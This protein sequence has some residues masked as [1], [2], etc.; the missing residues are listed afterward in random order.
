[1][2][3]FSPRSF[4]KPFEYERAFDY[5][6][7]QQSAHWLHLEI[8]MSADISDWHQNMNENEKNVVGN[9]LKS[10]TQTE[11]FIQEYWSNQ[12]M[13]W[14]KKPE[15]QMMASTF[16]SFE[17]IHSAGYDYLN[18]S[19]G[20]DDYQAFMLDS[21]AKAKID[22]LINTRGKSRAEIAKALAIFSAFNEGVNLFSSFAVLMSFPQRNLLK[23][24]GQ[25]V[26]WSIRD[27]AMHSEA[28]CWLFR[29]LIEEQPELFTEE[30]KKDIYDA[31][32]LTIELE[33][34]F[35]DKAFE[36]GPLPNLHPDDLKNYIRY[37][38]NSKLQEL[39]LKQNW[40]NLN[41]ESLD[42]LQWFDV[43]SSGVELADF[44]ATR[45][46]QY[47]KNVASFGEVW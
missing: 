41:K 23:G 33:D 1:M 36:L 2:S 12:V 28:G 11:T 20:L 7:K 14:F 39:G 35:I 30:L 29:T 37:R 31:A 40:K 34:A 47:S 26:S 42:K 44:F 38:A 18:S 6:L 5:W 9:I 13:K 22:R 45:N 17:S 15:I 43:L 4:Y 46:T 24:M 8:Q 27:E 32:R 16:A 3:I 10:F 25:I 19:L 21:A